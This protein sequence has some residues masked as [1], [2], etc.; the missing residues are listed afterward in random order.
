MKI[1]IRAVLGG[2]L[3]LIACS[4]VQS[5]SGEPPSQ[6]AQGQLLIWHPFEE[7]NARIFND[8]LT[9]YR[10][11]HPN[12]RMVSEYV[13]QAR[14]ADR[15][16]HQFETGLGPD[17]MITFSTDVPA[18]VAAETLQILDESAIDLSSYTPQALTQVHYHGKPYAIP[19]N[20]QIRVL[21]Y[22]QALVKRPS[23][24]VRTADRADLAAASLATPPTTLDEL[25]EQARSGHSVGLVSTFVD[26]FW[27]IRIFG[28]PIYES[29]QTLPRFKGW[30]QWL[31][32]L[33]QAANEPNMILSEQRFVLHDAF[34][35]GK[36]AY[37]VCD[38]TEIADF[39]ET[40][41][42]NLAVAALPGEPGH[43]A[44]PLFYA[45]VLL[46]SR[47]ASPAQTRLAYQLAQFLINPE[48]QIKTAVQSQDFLPVHQAVKIDQRVRPIEAILLEQAKTAVAIPLDDLD[49][50]EP[51]IDQGEMLFRQAI[52]GEMT[53]DEASARLT[54]AV[55]QALGSP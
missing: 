6:S 19:F 12:V 28:G 51:L 39:K 50:V 16:R 42:D 25:I 8:V 41:K 48:Q 40:L 52:T 11:I 10:R 24:P 21:C 55:N 44:G 27:G 26:T 1:L 23:A 4:P 17:V 37:Y 31:T 14:L 43:P 2:V 35:Q 7:T 29:D 34:S 54:Q 30:N 22:N 38:S 5:P 53:P 9:E 15:F 47:N 20:A 18:L 45:R 32:W 3:S 36:L 49:K 46:L 33:R 13:P